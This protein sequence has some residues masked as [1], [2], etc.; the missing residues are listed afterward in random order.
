[1]MHLKLSNFK[2]L[3]FSPFRGFLDQREKCS[4]EKSIT[5]SFLDILAWVFARKKVPVQHY[6]FLIVNDA[7]EMRDALEGKNLGKKRKKA[8][9]LGESKW[10]QPC[11][12][13]RI[14]AAVKLKKC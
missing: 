6:S 9:L 14:A 7:V 12:W 13:V 4:E 8:A 2:K 5:V 3:S 11:E 10:T 1:M